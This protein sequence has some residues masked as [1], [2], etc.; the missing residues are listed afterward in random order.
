[1]LLKESTD[2]ENQYFNMDSLHE[3]EEPEEDMDSLH[4]EEEEPEGR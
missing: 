1:M 4:E 3:E 2:S